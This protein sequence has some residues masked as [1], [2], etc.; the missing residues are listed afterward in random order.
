MI[1]M[2]AGLIIYVLEGVFIHTEICPVHGGDCMK[3][4]LK[5]WTYPRDN[6]N[7]A[8]R[9]VHAEAHGRARAASLLTP[10]RFLAPPCSDLTPT[11]PYRKLQTTPLP[12]DSKWD[13]EWGSGQDTKHYTLEHLGAGQDSSKAPPTNAASR[14]REPQARQ[15]QGVRPL[16]M[17][18][19]HRWYHALQEKGYALRPWMTMPTYPAVNQRSIA[20]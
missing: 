17:L 7:L 4:S 14:H 15:P 9:E 1:C 5:D 20:D 3:V 12:Q 8:V 16:R 19:T 10:H 2:H 13:W 11:L 6:S 18:L